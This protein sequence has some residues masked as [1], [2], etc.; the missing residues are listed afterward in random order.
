MSVTKWIPESI[1]AP[2]RGSP[3]F[4]AVYHPRHAARLARTTKRLDQC[5]AQLAH[6]LHLSGG[7][8]LEGAS[9]LE[10]GAGWVLTHA[11][12]CYLLGAKRV[13]AV[14]VEAAVR[15]ES[16]RDAVMG[17]PPAIV[18]DLLAPFSDHGDVRARLERLRAIKRF[19]QA[20]LAQLGIAY[21]APIDLARDTL[22]ET[23]DVIYSLSVL[24]HVPVD[25]VGALL[26]NLTRQ[27]VPGGTMLHMIHLE[28]HRD[29]A[30]EPFA[31]LRARAQAFSR[32]EQTERGNRMRA[33]AWLDAF[34]RVPDLQSRV[35]WAWQR[36]DV[37]LPAALDPAVQ[38]RDEADLRT[39]HLGIAARLAGARP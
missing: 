3:L 27:L 20:S 10:L 21:R 9:C 22:P 17:A 38:S 33:S 39:S 37:A 31:F 25:D 30:S 16:L 11:L 7:V 14:D 15:F 6:V 5:A 23:F 32:V 4:R 29:I 24:E 18:R 1:K 26:A 13:V 8:R 36:R 12:V 19:D 34:A 2:V 35:L 28:D